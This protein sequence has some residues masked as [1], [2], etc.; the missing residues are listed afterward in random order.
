MP[1]CPQSVP[2]IV[3]RFRRVSEMDFQKRKNRQ[4]NPFLGIL[5]V[6]VV[7]GVRLE[8]TTFGL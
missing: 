4:R 3:F 5:T 7:A 6:L 1:Q 2:E 8:L